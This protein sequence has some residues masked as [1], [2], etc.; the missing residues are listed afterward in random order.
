MG[1]INSDI[2][3]LE[4]TSTEIS[5]SN[6]DEIESELERLLERRIAHICELSDAIV[7][8]GEDEDIIKSIILSIR[9]DS[10]NASLHV[11]PENLDEVK[12]LYAGISLAERL[13]IFRRVFS[14]LYTSKKP[15]FKSYLD[16]FAKSRKA[17]DGRIAYVN[18]AYNDAA[19][20]AFADCIVGAT[21]HY[22]NGISKICDCVRDGRSEFCILPIE[23]SGDGKLLS[24]Y[25]T[26]LQHGLKI[27][28]VYDMQNKVDGEYTRYALLSMSVLPS[29]SVHRSR[30]K[31]RYFDFLVSSSDGVSISEIAMAAQLC[32]LEICSID[33]MTVKLD[34][35]KPQKCFF[36]SLKVNRG[37]INTFLSYLAVDCPG[38][39]SLGLYTRI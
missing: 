6:L 2:P 17:Y 20:L 36:I 15:F 27:N 9:Y 33:T 12:S 24:F 34:S 3:E 25:R 32:S 38:F 7:S 31:E 26:I 1:L 35:D 5:L 21:A 16:L 11:L 4:G 8:D 18:N 30:N 39:I 14:R 19:Y 28:L 29:T 23:T 37:D 22:E 10:E 13:M